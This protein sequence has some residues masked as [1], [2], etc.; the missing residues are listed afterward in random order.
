MRQ[1]QNSNSV[2]ETHKQ[3]EKTGQKSV[4][5]SVVAPEVFDERQRHK[6]G[7]F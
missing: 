3:Q 1:E 7:S 2:Y 6:G 4:C 5:M